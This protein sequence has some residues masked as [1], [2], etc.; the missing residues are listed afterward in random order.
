MSTNDLECN[1]RPYSHS[2][3]SVHEPC[4]VD[5]PEPCP[6]EPA[7]QRRR[8]AKRNAWH[9]LVLEREPGGLRH[10]LDDKPVHCGAGI[11]LQATTERSDDYGE[12][13]VLLDSG[14]TVRYEA[15]QY[16][17]KIDATLYIVVGGTEYATTLQPWMR[18]DWPDSWKKAR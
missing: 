14:N 13:T 7:R 4:E 18:F 2:G 1:R 15:S 8:D 16:K 9:E 12:Y 3:C 17:G 11:V 10:Y 6:L 5:G